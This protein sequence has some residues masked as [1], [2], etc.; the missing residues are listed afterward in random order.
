MNENVAFL[1]GH[2]W[3]PTATIWAG[4]LT[5]EEF[6]IIALSPPN[7]AGAIEPEQRCFYIDLDPKLPSVN[8][9]EVTL[10]IVTKLRYVIDEFRERDPI[11][12]H[13][14]IEI[15]EKK[16]KKAVSCT[17]DL[18]W[19][20]NSVGSESTEYRLKSGT[21]RAVMTKFYEVVST[22]CEKY[23]RLFL[24]LERLN[25]SLVRPK[26]IDRIIDIT[27]ALEA[28]VQDGKDELSFKFALY[29]AFA[30]IAKPAERENAFELL[31]ELYI[32]R[33]EI[34]HGA[35]DGKKL[36]KRVKDLMGRWAELEALARK[37]INYQVFYMAK[38]PKDM[39][40]PHLKKLVIRN[41]DRI[42][43]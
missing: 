23:P 1:P 39:W 30:A 29:N 8:V 34:V 15:D 24:T 28:M 36:S 22:A 14:A 41:G 43:L 42:N 18:G 3:T 9:A 31:R 6:G 10:N 2:A 21:T 4:K 13:F 11:C 5:A 40:I 17:H 38:E 27:I 12:M 25:S 26:E 16:K 33:S 35:K 20:G 32:T 7:I 37:A 19:T